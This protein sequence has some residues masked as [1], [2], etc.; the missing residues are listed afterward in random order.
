VGQGFCLILPEK[1][2]FAYN[3]ETL[4]VFHWLSNQIS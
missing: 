2:T 4:P 1:L 3:C